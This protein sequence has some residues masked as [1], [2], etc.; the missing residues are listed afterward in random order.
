MRGKASCVV[1]AYGELI[2]SGEPL[3]RS[4]R[5][6]RPMLPVA[7]NKTDE[8][9]CL[10]LRVQGFRGFRDGISGLFTQFLCILSKPGA[11]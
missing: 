2:A 9:T 5:V 7:A 6:R 1:Y 10:G 11:Q 4:C 8:G 3:V